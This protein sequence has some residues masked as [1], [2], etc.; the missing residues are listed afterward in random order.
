MSD[1]VC[2][3]EAKS[4]CASAVDRPRSSWPACCWSATATSAGVP[5]KPG[6]SR[7]RLEPSDAPPYSGF[8]T[9]VSPDTETTAVELLV[10]GE[11]AK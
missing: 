2:G 6:G 7:L 5:L 4:S 10:G 8:N 1:A 3:V 9:S 11:A